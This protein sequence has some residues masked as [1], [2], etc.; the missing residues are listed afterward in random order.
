MVE[1]TKEEFKLLL[2]IRDLRNTLGIAD[3]PDR[4]IPGD[5]L[6]AERDRL[7]QIVKVSHGIIT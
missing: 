7:L 1:L 4:I 2:E 3:H 5:D 6:Q